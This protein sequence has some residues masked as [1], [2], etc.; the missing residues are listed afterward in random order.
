V[1]RKNTRVT[2]VSLDEETYQIAKSMPNRSA[3]IRE[4]FRRWH[5]METS[6]HIHPNETNKCYPYSNNG[7]CALCW[8][9]GIPSLDDWKYYRET[10]RGEQPYADDWIMQKV[11][12]NNQFTIPTEWNRKKPSSG[13]DKPGGERPSMGFFAR[14]RASF[15]GNQQ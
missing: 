10:G 15:R 4:C 9:D 1:K 6:T 2:S 13:H 3:F 12:E 14:L 7:V 5:A 11:G 8:P